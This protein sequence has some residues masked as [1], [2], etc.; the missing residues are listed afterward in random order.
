MAAAGPASACA[1]AAAAALAS[2]ALHACA[3]GARAAINWSC[4]A[5]HCHAGDG[6]QQGL[7]PLA[8]LPRP[9]HRHCRQANKLTNMERKTQQR[10]Q[11]IGTTMYGQQIWQRVSAAGTTQGRQPRHRKPHGRLQAYCNVGPPTG[12][13]KSMNL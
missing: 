9:V 12:S 13:I 8:R 5:G 10:Q 3:A 6:V 7:R 2:S 11:L 4:Q 1:A